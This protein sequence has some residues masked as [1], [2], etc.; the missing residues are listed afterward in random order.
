MSERLHINEGSENCGSSITQQEFA[1]LLV[2]VQQIAGG[3]QCEVKMV[4]LLRELMDA[5]QS[6]ADAAFLD[7][8]RGSHGEPLQA[9]SARVLVG[10]FEQDSYMCS[11]LTTCVDYG[12]IDLLSIVASLEGIREAVV[13]HASVKG[14]KNATTAAGR[15]FDILSSTDPSINPG[16]G[17]SSLPRMVEFYA[18]GPVGPILADLVA[19]FDPNHKDVADLAGTPAHALIMQA[20]MRARIGGRAWPDLVEQ[21]TPVH[22][23]RARHV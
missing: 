9:K 3:E 13:K 21:A 10:G 2:R 7:I 14:N 4:D 15:W 19:Q 16:D 12:R 20:M 6:W 22:V 5:K 17:P 23:R 18:R 1:D 8:L 11:F